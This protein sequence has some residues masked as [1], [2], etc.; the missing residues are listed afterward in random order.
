[1]FG[2]NELV[3][4]S[5]NGMV[6]FIDREVPL[7]EFPFLNELTAYEKELYSDVLNELL[8]KRRKYPNTPIHLTVM[9]K[10]WD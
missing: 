10:E 1:M 3:A 4:E 9:E 6:P 8:E 5:Y 7:D 2:Y